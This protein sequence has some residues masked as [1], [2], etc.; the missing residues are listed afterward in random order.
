MQALTQ[1]ILRL[2]ILDRSV[3]ARQL[4]K[5]VLVGVTN[6][7]WDYALYILLTRGWVGFRLHF[8][9]AQLIAF[10]GAVLNSYTLNKKWTFRD[11]DPR[12]HIQ[13]S[14][15]F[16]VNLVTLASYELLLYALVDRLMMFDLM[17]KAIALVP[18]TFWNFVAN[19]YWTFRKQAEPADLHDS[20]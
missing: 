8:L 18:V 1:F 6:T 12:H 10:L 7:F 5:F 19:K 15:F 11:D 20:S 17:A 2:P 13:L 3:T 9:A 4:V 16:V 14:K